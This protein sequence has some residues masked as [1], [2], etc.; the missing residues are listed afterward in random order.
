MSGFTEP[1]PDLVQ[2]QPGGPQDPLGESVLDP[3][4]P[5]Y[6]I[7]EPRD[8]R[9]V[10]GRHQQAAREC[11]VAEAQ[12]DGI[13][14]HRRVAGGGAVVLAPGMVVVAIRLAATRVGTSCYFDLVNQALV[15]AVAACGVT[16]ACRGYGDLTVVGDDGVTRK[17]LGASLRQTSRMVVYLGV[18]LVEDA[19]PLMERYLHAP[20]REPDYRA[21]RGHRAFCTHLGALG[22]STPALI[23]AIE[24]SCERILGREALR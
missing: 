7:F 4:Q 20:S 13:P 5:W 1:T 22:V 19:V 18:F 24:H 17:V 16:A 12:A 21:G 6:R 23:R 8:V 2:I 14:V 11:R 9:L 3:T 10:I 15:P